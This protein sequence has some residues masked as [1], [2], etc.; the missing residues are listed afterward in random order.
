MKSN[1]D[2]K[3]YQMAETEK[4]VM[5]EMT[6]Q[7]LEEILESLS[8]Q[9]KKR[10]MNM[11]KIVLLVA[12]LSLLCSV[13]VTASVGLL[14]KRMEDLNKKK[15]EE[16]FV[17]IYKTKVPADNYNRNLTTAEKE[18]KEK[19]WIAYSEQ[20]KFPESEICLIDSAEDYKG[21]SIAYLQDTGTFFF[22]EKE[23]SDEE[24]LQYIDFLYKRD[25]SLKKINEL[26]AEGEMEEPEEIY[27]KETIEVTDE[28]ILESEAIWNPKQELTI[29]YEG[30]LSVTAIAAGKDSIYLGSI[31][32]VHKMAIGD[33]KSDV[34]FD[35]F[36]KETQVTF[37]HEDG[38]G[39]VY[40]AGA[41]LEINTEAEAETPY[42]L[43]PR[44]MILWKVSA[45]GELLS[46]VNLSTL[47]NGKGGFVN[48]LIADEKGNVYIIGLKVN[49]LHVLNP[50][51]E[52][53]T[54]IDSGE[55]RINSAGGMG[56]GKDG[57]VYVTVYQMV[58]NDRRLGIAT[59]NLDKGCLDNVYEGIVPDGTIM[60]DVITRGAETDF[61]FW[62]YDGIFTYNLGDS[63]A[64]HVMHAY[65]MP[66]AFEAA[67][68]CGLWDGRILIASCNAYKEEAYGNGW[69]R[70][71][72]VPEETYFYYLS[73]LKEK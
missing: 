40:I 21:K 46:K 43:P 2:D 24:I 32:T 70:H 51:G 37:I 68:A 72:R 45:N 30:E 31:N 1:F 54:E 28:R 61:V 8:F 49:R 23:M 41:E 16:F 38:K 69:I 3:L 66:C 48:E 44:Q 5:P 63:E 26:I 71:L 11:K 33:S 9:R 29:P 34:F 13:T 20:G 6:Q 22:P 7:K 47:M 50:E 56:V 58:E 53:L 55:F 52:L 59:I 19:L 64:V 42:Y 18:R 15:L 62:G 25:Y 73:A 36:E 17:Q 65:E 35:D 27:E 14:Q 39:N 57:K 4:V 67:P 10:M 12:V 60:L